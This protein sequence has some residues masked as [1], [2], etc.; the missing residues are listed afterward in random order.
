[1]STNDLTA[2][3][4]PPI[5]R[6]ASLLRPAGSASLAGG[7]RGITPRR[8]AVSLLVVLAI[9]L[10]V[11][12]LGP[13]RDTVSATSISMPAERGLPPRVGAPAPDFE[14]TTVD[15]KRVHLTELRGH[16]VWIN[17][18][19]SWCPPCRAEAPE[20]EMVW[21]EQRAS[22]LVLLGISQAEDA[23]A[24]QSY[25]ATAGLT[26]D[27]IADRDQAIGARYRVNGLPTHYF[28][29]GEGIVQAIDAGGLTKAAML[30]RLSALT[31]GH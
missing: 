12:Y 16:P 25:A 31:P 30:R 11:Y 21:R 20:I 8:V 19:A 14:A 18:W 23:A 2:P 28:I 10:S 7:E 29:D 13:A 4:D 24:V 6:A 27:L 26:F 17:F 1:M 15:G 3:A 9:G 5:D 22:G